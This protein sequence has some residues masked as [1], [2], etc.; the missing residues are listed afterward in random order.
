MNAK[1]LFYS[2]L[3][4]TLVTSTKTLA[5]DSN[6]VSVQAG[7]PAEHE[8]LSIVT[9]D[10][11]FHHMFWQWGD[12]GCQFGLGGRGGMLK[13][14]G[15]STARLGGGA[16]M[17]CRWNNWTGWIPADVVWL[18][19]HQFGQRGNGFKDYGGPVQFAFGIGVGYSI[20]RNWLIGYQY[21]HMSN[22]YRYDKNPGLDS[23]NLHIEYRF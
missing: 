11:K 22:A 19:Q 7:R 17:E 23:H 4:I 12:S 10:I 5:S 9:T 18:D 6:I 16:R 20:S 21:E 14:G 8:R 15:E 3:V 13:V 2:G 1:I